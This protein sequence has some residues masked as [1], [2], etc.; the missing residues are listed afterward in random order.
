MGTQTCDQYSNSIGSHA[1]P[2][3]Q[4]SAS[5]SQLRRNATQFGESLLQ[6]LCTGA[7]CGA[8]GSPDAQ[9]LRVGNRSR[10]YGRRSVGVS[11]SLSE[12]GQVSADPSIVCLAANMSKIAWP[13]AQSQVPREGVRSKEF[14]GHD[15]RSGILARPAQLTAPEVNYV[16]RPGD[17]RRATA[18]AWAT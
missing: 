4:V 9:F 12:S 15:K 6:F 3:G 16:S 5:R 10:M 14:K 17:R 1:S 18:W 2:L 8:S 7:A 11:P 13:R